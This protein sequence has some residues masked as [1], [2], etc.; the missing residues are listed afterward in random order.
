MLA[1]EGMVEHAMRYHMAFTGGHGGDGGGGFYDHTGPRDYLG[2]PFLICAYSNFR[3]SESCR[4][5][6]A[7]LRCSAAA[8]S[9]LSLLSS[10]LVMPPRSVAYWSW[11]VIRRS[12]I[13]VE[14]SADELCDML[15]LASSPETMLASVEDDLEEFAH[16]TRDCISS[17][18]SAITTAAHTVRRVE[19]VA[20]AHSI[21]GHAS[22]ASTSTLNGLPSPIGRRDYLLAMSMYTL[23]NRVTRRAAEAMTDVA[24]SAPGVWLRYD[25]VDLIEGKL[26]VAGVLSGVGSDVLKLQHVAEQLTQDACHVRCGS[27]DCTGRCRVRAFVVEPCGARFFFGTQSAVRAAFCDACASTVHMM[28]EYTL[29]RVARVDAMLLKTLN[30]SGYGGLRMKASQLRSA[31]GLT[32]YSCDMAAWTRYCLETLGSQLNLR[33]EELKVKDANGRDVRAYGPPNTTQWQ[34]QIEQLRFPA[35]MPSDVYIVGLTV[36]LD[37]SHLTDDQ[38][39]KQY[40]L[41]AMPSG[42]VDEAAWPPCA[43]LPAHSVDNP[44]QERAMKDEVLRIIF[45]KYF[46]GQTY[47]RCGRSNAGDVRTTRLRPC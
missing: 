15:G 32:L 21:G 28:D 44:R 46:D 30:T 17:A 33:F 25:G 36:S 1:H 38:T 45:G 22:A 8:A 16:G 24:E 20:S 9:S 18:G 40:P 10:L 41:Y 14:R 42:L 12:N 29:H 27:G 11:P 47:V 31:P 43:L 13:S 3:W 37:V 34:Q 35:G 6:L 5:G 19:S 26:E 39:R 23:A 7:A 2:P 4:K